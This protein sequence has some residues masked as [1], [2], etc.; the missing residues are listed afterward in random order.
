MTGHLKRTPAGTVHSGAR[1]SGCGWS[2]ALEEVEGADTLR[3]IVVF[4]Q[5]FAI[6]RPGILV[7]EFA[8]FLHGMEN[9]VCFLGVFDREAVGLKG[10]C[11]NW[12]PGIAV[13]GAA[14][15]Q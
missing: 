3:E 9:I 4:G 1:Y 11:E 12:E 6:E 8:E 14:C 13:K 10:I 7:E 2:S 15:P 5:P